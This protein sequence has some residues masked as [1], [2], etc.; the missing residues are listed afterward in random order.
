MRSIKLDAF[1]KDCESCMILWVRFG[2]RVCSTTRCRDEFD[3]TVCTV[4]RTCY[5][6][7]WLT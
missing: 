1:V 7:R 3:W 6:V 5:S 4:S 2:E